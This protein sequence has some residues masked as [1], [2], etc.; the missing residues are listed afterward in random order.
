MLITADCVRYKP[1]TLF[2]KPQCVFQG[3]DGALDGR[4]VSAG[5]HVPTGFE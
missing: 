5:E 3:E 4:Q 2:A 1:K